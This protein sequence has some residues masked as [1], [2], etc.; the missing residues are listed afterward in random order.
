MI[1]RLLFQNPRYLTLILL[2][3][4]A[5]GSTS[6]SSLGRQEDPTITPF[7][8]KIET[9]FPG[10]SPARVESL[11]TKPLE[12]ALREVPEVTEITSTSAAGVSVIA[13]ETDYRLSLS[14]IERVW[15]ELRDIVAAEA[16]NFPAGVE[17]PSFDDDIITAYV[18]ILAISAKPGREIPPSVLRRE[19]EILA[20]A[21]RGIPKTKRVTLYGAPEEEVLV[22][23]DETQ[24]AFLGIS[25]SEVSDILRRADARTP[26]GSLTGSGSDIAVE[27]AGEFTNLE[28]LRELQVRALPNGRTLRLQDIAKLT[29]TERTPAF[30]YALSNGRRSVL[31]GTEMTQ[32]Y[33]ADTYGARFDK[34]LDD[35]RAQAPEGLSIEIAYDQSQYTEAR[36]AGV[37]SN[38]FAGVCIVLAVLLITLGWRAALV[39][40]LILPLCT[41]LS[42]LALLYLEVPIHQ[43]SL[44]GLVV[45][46]G[47]LVDGS[48]VMTD[49]VRK[50]LITGMS[51]LQAL[52]ASVSRLRVPLIASTATT[53]L[54]FLPMAILEGPAGDFLGSIALSVI[55]ML[56]ASMLLSLTVTPVLAA[57]LLPT[58]LND[59]YQWWRVGVDLPQVSRIF[60]KLL[61]LSLRNPAGSIALAL[62]LPVA[63]FLSASTLTNQFFPGTDRDQLYLQITLTESASID[64]ALHLAT[65]IDSDLAKEALIRRVDWTIGESAPAFYY[66]M[67][68]NKKGRPSWLEALILTTDEDTTD[69]LIRRL[70]RQLD[71]DYPSAQIIVRG[72]DQGPPVEAPLEITVSGPNVNKLKELGEQFRQRMDALPDVTHTKVSME[73]GPP[74]LVFH[75]E[76]EKLKQVGLSRVQ[77]ATALDAALRGRLGGELLEDTERL[78]VRTRLARKD[79]SNSNV[80]QNMRIPVQQS[81]SGVKAVPLSALGTAQLEPDDSPITRENGER[82]NRVQAFLVRGVLPEEALKLLREKLNAD[83]I[84]LPPGYYYS[85]GGDTDERAGVIEDLMA[86]LGI[87]TAALVATILL[88]FNSWRLSGIAVLVCGCSFGL[89][90]FALALFRYP[91]GI[92]PLIGVIGSIGVSI[93]AAIII[94]TALQQDSKAASGDAEAVI[95]VVRDSSRHIVSTTVTTFGGFLPLILEGSRF[96]PPFAMAIAGGVLLSTVISFFLV[97]PLFY[98]TVR[99][100]PMPEGTNKIEAKL[101]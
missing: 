90:L 87:I 4:V 101:A 24:L 14:G 89:S 47:L 58:G 18:K 30:S 38:L 8:A 11:V 85:F 62:C 82:L 29:R 84:E 98:L 26:A 97:P 33:Q 65:Q 66:N 68:S 45:A 94:L 73:A 5:V 91:L 51:P 88:T 2:I 35:Y 60:A 63:G 46:L 50:R 49:E 48:I 54:A 6:Y 69:A 75:L 53:V 93:N 70:Q 80:L 86:P 100:R 37:A 23:L 22:E 64:D 25:V 81:A 71:Y 61:T 67:R 17:A 32:G 3:I 15:S 12:D 28:T 34:F 36:L 52:G 99:P 57:R 72:I 27:L 40:A 7:I 56:L 59:G 78:P 44:T 92:N 10:A 76:E 43:M 9:F 79:W 1:A 21:I 41:L 39:V 20:D 77:V 19:A 13:I 42:M 31:L 16:A 74:K 95:R 55:V 83:P 96:W